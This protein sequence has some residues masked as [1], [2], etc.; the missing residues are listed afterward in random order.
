ML[1]VTAAFSPPAGT[2]RT[3]AWVGGS[4]VGA[5]VLVLGFGSGVG[6]VVTRGH[7][8]YQ[9]SGPVAQP[10]P[11]GVGVAVQPLAGDGRSAEVH[12]HPSGNEMA[13][14]AVLPTAPT[15]RP[16]AASVSGPSPTAAA[17]AAVAAPTCAARQPML[18]AM[19]AP[20]VD[21]LDKAHFE[22]GPGQQVADLLSLDQYVKTHT[23]LL[24]SVLSPLLDV[25]MAVPQGLAPLVGHLDRA[26][27]EASPGQQAADVLAVDQYVR[28][29]TALVGDVAAPALAAIQG[30]PSC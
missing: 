3:S 14:P 9:A 24:E 18:T 17:A 22:T 8:A 13:M 2:G 23:A 4:L 19:M 21:H 27:L 5:V 25:V 28:T 20:L 15:T 29:H 7:T 11:G 26:H 12:G 10:G 1:L 30:G 16:T 6:T